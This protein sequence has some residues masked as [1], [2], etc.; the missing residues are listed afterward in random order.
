M[1]QAFTPGKAVNL[2]ILLQ[3]TNR[4]ALN[5]PMIDIERLYPKNSVVQSLEN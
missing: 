2:I 4:I 5:R 3:T 1:S